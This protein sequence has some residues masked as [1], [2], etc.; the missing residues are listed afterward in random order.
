M[1]QRLR[2]G[3]LGI[4][5]LFTP[6]EFDGQPELLRRAKLIIGFATLG[7]FFGLGFAGFYLAIGHFWGASI[8]VICSAIFSFIPFFLRQSGSADRAGNLYCLVL[9]GGFFSLCLVE[10]G[11]H[12][13]ALA[14]L[15]TV[16]LCALLF[17]TRRAAHRWGAVSLL[18]AM[19][20]VGADLLG[21]PLPFRYPAAWHNIIT[22][23]G[24]VALVAFMFILGLI[25]ETGRATAHDRMQQTLG[26]LAE[27]NRHLI[28]LN[29]EKNEF[30]GIAAHDLKNPLTVVMAYSEMLS[31][32]E[33]G[34]ARA[35]RFANAINREATRMRDLI[36]SLLDLNAIE[37]GRS[38]IELAC[39][40]LEPLA[41]RSVENL[42]SVAGK[43]SIAIALESSSETQVLGDSNA[44]LQILDN[45]IS[46]AVK[47]SKAGSTV[48]VAVSTAGGRA[49]LR[50]IDQGPGISAE[51]HAKLFKRFSKLSARPT[52]GE[53]SNGLGLSIVKRLAEAMH[54]TIRCESELGQGAAFVL[55]LPLPAS[56][57]NVPEHRRT[58]A[59]KE[60]TRLGGGWSLGKIGSA[61][62]HTCAG[63]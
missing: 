26:E 1:R 39:F 13:H 36:S 22:A 48:R 49:E 31:A 37:S 47:F 14:W 7:G 40:P 27:A 19:V 43:K 9:I 21:H 16:P 34:N 5:R 8:V 59:S 2:E 17:C 45:L 30:L 53:S 24:Y 33:S 42:Q 58:G 25:F 55:T 62:A 56:G 50:V 29:E 41:R 51:D 54:G 20:V 38:S 60:P 15:V 52:A 57:V 6:P 44:L 4:L 28:R 35:L 23:A 46:N 12:G 32:D 3:A 63:K 18:A 61:K 11:M 10:G